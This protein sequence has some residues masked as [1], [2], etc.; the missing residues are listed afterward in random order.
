MNCT[1]FFEKSPS[2]RTIATTSTAVSQIVNPYAM[3]SY[4]ITVKTVQALEAELIRL[5][6]STKDALKQSWEEVETLQQQCAAHL[7]I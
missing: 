6:E 4:I 2:N 5:R 7:D 1:H 3:S